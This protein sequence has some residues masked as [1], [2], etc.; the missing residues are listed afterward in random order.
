[1]LLKDYLKQELD[2]SNL[3]LYIMIQNM[4]LLRYISKKEKLDFKML[5]KKYLNLMKII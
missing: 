1:M 3:P 2:K 5:C 4:E